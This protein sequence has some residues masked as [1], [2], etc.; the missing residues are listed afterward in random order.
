MA[1]LIRDAEA[2]R[3]IRELAERAGETITE[4]VRT[5]VQ[6]RLAR[7]PPRRGRIDRAKLAAAQA[8]FRSLPSRNEGMSDDEIVGYN[9]EGHFD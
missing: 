7:L 3:L 8:Y 6:Q 1:V 4:A 9:S 2:D 5:A